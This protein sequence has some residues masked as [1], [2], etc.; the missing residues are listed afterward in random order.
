MQ[1]QLEGCKRNAQVFERISCE[2]KDIGYDRTG[3]QCREK[4]KKLRGEYKKIKDKKG[5]TGEGNKPWKYFENLDSVLGHKPA[6]CPPI[7]VDISL[8]YIKGASSRRRRRE[9]MQ[10]PIAHV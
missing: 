4:I 8:K 9:G 2:M 3:V 5:K 6:T 10:L 7:V 1:A